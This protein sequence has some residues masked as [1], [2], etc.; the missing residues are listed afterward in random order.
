M[1]AVELILLSFS[2]S[3]D[4]I[5]QDIKNEIRKIVPIIKQNSIMLEEFYEANEQGIRPEVKFVISS[6]NYNREQ[7]LEYMGE[8]YKIVRTSSTNPDEVSLICEHRVGN[9]KESNSK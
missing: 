5:G 8:R 1:I 3:K 4:E 2:V 7:E 9:V 6:L